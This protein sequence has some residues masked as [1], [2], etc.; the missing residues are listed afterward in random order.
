MTK[1]EMRREYPTVKVRT[2]H[3]ACMAGHLDYIHQAE[4]ENRC[5]AND[6]RVESA[7]PQGPDCWRVQLRCVH[8]DDAVTVTVI[9]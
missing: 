2:L 8:C 6:F 9:S 4:L 1:L 7:H 3:S 5:V